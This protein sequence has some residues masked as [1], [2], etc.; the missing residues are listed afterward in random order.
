MTAI[1]LI[2]ISSLVPY[3]QFLVFISVVESALTANLLPFLPLKGK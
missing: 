2:I 1:E 3:L